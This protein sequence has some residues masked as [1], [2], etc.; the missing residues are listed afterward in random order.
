[1]QNEQAWK[2]C[3]PGLST[4]LAGRLNSSAAYQRRFPETDEIG[5][6]SEGLAAHVI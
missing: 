2:D 4:G 5:F 1:M 3:R 6:V